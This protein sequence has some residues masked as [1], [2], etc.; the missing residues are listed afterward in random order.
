MIISVDPGEARIGF[1]LFKGD[2]KQNGTMDLAVMT[3]LRG[4]E[5]LHGVLMSAEGFVSKGI[6]ISTV[7]CENYRIRPPEQPQGNSRRR[8]PYGRSAYGSSQYSENYAISAKD[9]WSEVK[10]I[11]VIGALEFFA[12]RVGAEFVLQEPKDVLT[13]GRKWCDLPG[14]HKKHLDDDLSAYIHGAHYLMKKGIVRSVDN[15]TKFGQDVIQ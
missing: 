2:E 9:F 7:V 3:I 1:C 15:I 13:M 10:T 4:P 11:R 6:K 12:F 5:E 14:A 8:Q